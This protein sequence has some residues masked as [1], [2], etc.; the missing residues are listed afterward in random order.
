MS[1]FTGAESRRVATVLVKRPIKPFAGDLYG[2]DDLR[3]WAMS[4]TYRCSYNL[5]DAPTI[6]LRNP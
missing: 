3:E 6:R 1:D 5:R 2:S 4:S